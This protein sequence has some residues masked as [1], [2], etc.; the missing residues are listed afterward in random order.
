MSRLSLNDWYRFLESQFE[1]R[2]DAPPAQEPHT[3]EPAAHTAPPPEPQN[4]TPS[5]VPS[6]EPPTPT[7]ESLPNSPPSRAIVSIRVPH[8]AEFVPLLRQEMG[9]QPP[10]N[11]EPDPTDLAETHHSDGP[12]LRKRTGH[13]KRD[14]EAI[15]PPEA[16]AVWAKLPQYLR[17][18]AE[19]TDDRVTRKY[20]PVRGRDESR[21]ELIAR[22]TDPVLTLEETARLLGVCPATVRRYTDRGWLR[23]FR[24]E[25]NQR[26]FK[27][28]DIVAFLEEQA[29]RQPRGNRSRT[30]EET[31]P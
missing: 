14:P 27:L 9:W 19:W 10:A 7:S 21:E 8:F 4:P 5:A 3:A 1:S 11:T 25:G 15:V 23:C 30:P 2:E 26:R 22:L 16:D 13:K 28:S 17:Y 31:Q 18:L 20:Y 12:R 24:T 6:P 29:L